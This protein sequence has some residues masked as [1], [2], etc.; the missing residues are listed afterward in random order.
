MRILFLDDDD[1]RV[2][3]FKDRTGLDVVWAK[4]CSEFIAY[5]QSNRFDYIFLDHD[6]DLSGPNAGN[7]MDAAK[8]LAD[9]PGHVS[10]DTQVVIHSWNSYGVANMVN[11]LK[12]IDDMRLHVIHGAW[13][14]VF[15]LNNVQLAFC[16]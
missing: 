9:N 8:F 16:L 1:Y 15:M 14:R 11:V 7:G 13:H 3:D 2:A 12:H 5:L 4:T 10:G 6:L